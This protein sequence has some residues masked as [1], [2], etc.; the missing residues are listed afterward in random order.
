MGV[1]Y[2]TTFLRRKFS[3]GSLRQKWPPVADVDMIPGYLDF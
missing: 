1:G 2:L 3:A